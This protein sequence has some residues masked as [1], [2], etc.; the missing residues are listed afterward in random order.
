MNRPLPMRPC[1]E[2]G[3]HHKV[4]ETECPF[5]GHAEP[6]KTRIHST[7]AAALSC[8]VLMACYG[9][10]VGDFDTGLGD[11]ADMDVDADGYTPAEGDCDD[12]DFD[13]NP[14]AAEDCFD[15]IDNDCDDLIDGDDDDCA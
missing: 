10:P 8:F 6:K 14:G 1:P 5:C 7:V 2:C 4:T 9:A 13:V 3:R 15:G 11:T 12:S